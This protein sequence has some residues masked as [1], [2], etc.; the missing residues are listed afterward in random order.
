MEVSAREPRAFSN[1][2]RQH[3]H[4]LQLETVLFTIY[5][6]SGFGSGQGTSP[7]GEE[8]WSRATWLPRPRIEVAKGYGKFAGIPEWLSAGWFGL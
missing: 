5:Y 1:I 7:G 4:I 2:K 3:R 6:P 8:K